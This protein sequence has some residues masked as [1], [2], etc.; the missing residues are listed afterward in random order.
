MKHIIESA[1]ARVETSSAKY[2]Y[3][4]LVPNIKKL[5]IGDECVDDE[6]VVIF[7]QGYIRSIAQ[8]ISI[9]QVGLDGKVN[10]VQLNG[11]NFKSLLHTLRKV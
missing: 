6:S 9:T 4:D 11:P 5:K 1:S 10:N 8:S 3:S 7:H 2:S